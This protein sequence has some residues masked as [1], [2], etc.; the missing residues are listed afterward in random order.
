M[1]FSG[2]LYNRLQSGDLVLNLQNFLELFAVFDHDDVGLTIDG[3][4]EAR[5]GRIGG[6]DPRGETAA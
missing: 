6:V 4:V 5:L 3:A 2:V 1:R